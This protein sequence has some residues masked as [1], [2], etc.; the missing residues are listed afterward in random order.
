[1]ILSFIISLLL[2]NLTQLKPTCIEGINNC[3]KCN[4]LTKLCDK[5][6]LEI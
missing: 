2:I 3:L 1:M 4:P 5:C 6:T